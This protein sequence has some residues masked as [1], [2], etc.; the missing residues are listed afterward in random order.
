M[1]NITSVKMY[2][3]KWEKNHIFRNIFF[4]ISTFDII[5]KY[6]CSIFVFMLCLRDKLPGDSKTSIHLPLAFGKEE[7]PTIFEL[8]AF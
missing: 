5:E 7:L 2:N 6:I 4:A 1:I 8:L 3:M